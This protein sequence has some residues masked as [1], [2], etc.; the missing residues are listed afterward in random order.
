MRKQESLGLNWRDTSLGILTEVAYVLTII[1]VAAV[2]SV[3]VDWG[4]R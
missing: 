3:L 4:V 1:A 2:L